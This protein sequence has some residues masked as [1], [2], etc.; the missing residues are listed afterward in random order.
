MFDAG[1]TCNMSHI[2]H[3]QV[4]QASGQAIY[5]SPNTLSCVFD[6]IHSERALGV[7]GSTTWSLGGNR[8][9]YNTLRLNTNNPANASVLFDLSNSTVISSLVEGNGTNPPIQYQAYGGSNVTFIACEWQSTAGLVSGNV[10]TVN[11]IGGSFAKISTNSLAQHFYGSTITSLTLG[12]SS[13]NPLFCTF[14]NC[15]IA[16]LASSSAVSS[17]TFTDCSIAEC[18]S[19]LES[20]TVLNNTV[21]TSASTINVSYRT[22]NLNNSTVN[23]NVSID[24]GSINSKGSRI[25]G[26]LTQSAGSISSLFDGS[27]Y[28]TGAVSGLGVVTGGTWSRGQRTFNLA[29]VGGSPKSWV[30][31]VAGTPG[32]WVSEG[33]L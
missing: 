3:L 10:G 2:V 13:G 1:D 16:T 28:A 15:T 22:L 4:E 33:N 11:F 31:T 14:N 29:P 9:T 18:N 12:F 7:G 8:C 17:A 6:N 25:S 21:A 26:T 24:N 30:C 32:T 20:N 23:G 19:F 5:I 27:S